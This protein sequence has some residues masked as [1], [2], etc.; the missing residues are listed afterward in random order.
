MYFKMLIYGVRND[1][2]R[3]YWK[4]MNFIFYRVFM[5]N[6]WPLKYICD[7]AMSTKCAVN[8]IKGIL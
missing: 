3:A 2:F 4:I 6:N 8:K 1:I 7:G 5:R